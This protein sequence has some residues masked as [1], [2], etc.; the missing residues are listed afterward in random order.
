MDPD[1]EDLGILQQGIGSV[2]NWHS[3]SV[4]KF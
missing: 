3:D 4:D 2:F 1:C